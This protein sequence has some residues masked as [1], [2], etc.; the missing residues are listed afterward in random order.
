[1]PHPI[2][3][4]VLSRAHGC[5]L[6]QFAGDS[7]GSLVEFVSPAEILRRYPNRVRDLADGGTWNTLAGQPT[8]DSEMALALARSLVADGRFVAESVRAA[9]LDWLQSHPF[10]VGNTIGGSLRGRVN[11]DS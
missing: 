5:L 7:L 11:P 6:G 3:P 2:P 8:D 1:M 4:D 10:D 9:Y